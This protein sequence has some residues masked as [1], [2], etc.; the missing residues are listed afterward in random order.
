MK[1]TIKIGN[2]INKLWQICAYANGFVIITRR[3]GAMR[4]V[5]YNIEI[6]GGTMD[7]KINEEKTKYVHET[8]RD[9]GAL[10]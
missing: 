7:L 1:D 2:I 3:E 4:E 5:Y 9:E 8:I 6:K 10:V